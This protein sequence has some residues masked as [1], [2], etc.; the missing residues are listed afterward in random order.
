MKQCFKHHAANSLTG[1]GLLFAII[2]AILLLFD[3]PLWFAISIVFI[4]AI[5]D[6]LD[7]WLARQLNAV[8]TLGRYLDVG[9][10][11]IAFGI[12]PAFIVL[13]IFDG[14]QPLLL[15]MVSIY[16]FAMAF[17]LIRSLRYNSPETLYGLPAPLAGMAVA[18]GCGVIMRE[19]DALCLIWLLIL[20]VVMVVPFKINR[21]WLT[22][23]R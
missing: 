6:G 20:I 14:L 2:T 22:P 9:H 5:I 10:D 8:S 23:T 12:V 7:G 15:S 11:M 17:R 3:G 21:P 4:C 16:V 18:L 1:L 13:R 19:V